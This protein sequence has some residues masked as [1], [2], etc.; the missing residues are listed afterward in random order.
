MIS[1]R[2]KKVI[3]NELDLSK[4][5][6]KD[7]TTANQVPGW[8]SFNHI[9]VILA[10]EKEYSIHFKGLEILRVKNIGELQKLID[11]K[12]SASN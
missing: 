12:L 5:D 3:L 7:E 4:F 11:S 10:V 8:D 1:E 9:N 2:L 6:L